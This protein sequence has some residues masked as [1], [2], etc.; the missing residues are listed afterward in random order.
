MDSLQD[1]SDE[2]LRDLRSGVLAELERRA[3]V[4]TYQDQVTALQDAYERATM[5]EVAR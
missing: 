4:S 1:L 2:E 5:Q 3:I